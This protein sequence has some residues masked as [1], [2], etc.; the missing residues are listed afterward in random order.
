MKNVFEAL[1]L[2]GTAAFSFWTSVQAFFFIRIRGFEV[3]G[4]KVEVLRRI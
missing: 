3:V 1:T 4:K 2:I